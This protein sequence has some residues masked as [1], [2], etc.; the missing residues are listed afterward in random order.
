[1]LA[2]VYGFDMDVWIRARGGLTCPLWCAVK[3]RKGGG[4]PGRCGTVGSGLM[5]RWL[6]AQTTTQGARVV[7]VREMGAP[8]GGC[9][10]EMLANYGSLPRFCGASTG[11]LRCCQ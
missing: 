8:A 4:E 7:R 2:A 11:L 6:W 10:T 9:A 3:R 1:M 5:E